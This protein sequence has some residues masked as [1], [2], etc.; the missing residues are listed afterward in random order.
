[1]KKIFLITIMSV[2]LSCDKDDIQTTV[3]YTLTVSASEGGTIQQREGHM[4][5]GPN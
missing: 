4:T 3:Q 5:K 2:L 1:M